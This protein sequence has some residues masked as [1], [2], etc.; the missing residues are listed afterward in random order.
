MSQVSRSQREE[1]SNFLGCPHPLFIPQADVLLLIPPPRASAVPGS[2]LLSC[3]PAALN[4]SLACDPSTVWAPWTL[5]FLRCESFTHL[6]LGW[7][8]CHSGNQ[9]AQYSLP[10]PFRR[11]FVTP[12]LVPHQLVLCLHCSWDIRWQVLLALALT[13]PCANSVASS[14]GGLAGGRA[15][16]EGTLARP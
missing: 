8:V 6:R 16:L 11:M 5:P 4:A 2:Q 14:R 3:P 10:Y 7:A 1:G 9:P 13:Q 15:G 12:L